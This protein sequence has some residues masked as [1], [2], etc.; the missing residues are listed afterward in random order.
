MEE[1]ENKYSDITLN[2][3]WYE[4]RYLKNLNE[5]DRALNKRNVKPYHY[6]SFEIN[7]NNRI[8]LSNMKTILSYR[9]DSKL[10][11]GDRFMLQSV[12]GYT[13]S[14]DLALATKEDN[15][16]IFCS[17]DKDVLIRKAFAVGILDECVERPVK[18]GDKVCITFI[19]PSELCSRTFYLASRIK[20]TV[21]YTE[22]NKDQDVYLTPNLNSTCHW[23][24]ESF[25]KPNK[26][27]SAVNVN[28]NF[29]FKHCNTNKY[30]NLTNTTINTDYGTGVKVS[31]GLHILPFKEQIL[32]KELVGQQQSGTKIMDES[33]RWRIITF[34][35]FIN[36]QSLLMNGELDI[37]V[38]D[39]YKRVQ[40]KIYNQGIF[41]FIKFRNWLLLLDEQKSGQFDKELLKWAFF[42]C[43]IECSGIELKH[44]IE[45]FNNENASIDVLM[46]RLNHYISPK[47][48]VRIKKTM[49]N[50][51]TS[52][53][54]LNIIKICERL[55]QNGLSKST[56]TEFLQSLYKDDPVECLKH[57]ELHSIFMVC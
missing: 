11:N 31:S 41:G 36:I 34:Q 13:L 43:K 21:T 52:N 9:E 33:H 38:Y 57:N 5:N 50:M 30:F 39:L 12:N 8:T 46:T 15:Y 56:I 42:N 2:G 27:G 6:K 47:R 19:A 14:A 24:I 26:Y 49:N 10:Y 3:N 29:L 4:K 45:T 51:I 22:D 55:E 20:D 32:Y 7:K 17:K 18:Y 48:S 16:H 25:E 37:F 54:E 44:I 35:R 23:I 40:E 1:T 53:P 28:D